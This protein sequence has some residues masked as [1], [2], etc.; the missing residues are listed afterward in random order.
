M[1]AKLQR[2][3]LWTV[4]TPGT[5]HAGGAQSQRRCGCLVEQDDRQQQGLGSVTSAVP[6]A[7]QQAHSVDSGKASLRRMLVSLARAK[8]E[9]GCGAVT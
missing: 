5:L 2:V 6:E 7:K 3:W 8:Q 9:H 1:V 4:A